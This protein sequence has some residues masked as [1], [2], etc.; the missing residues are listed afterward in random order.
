MAE[1]E[2]KIVKPIPLA[3]PS[4][5]FSVISLLWLLFYSVFFIA[6]LFQKNDI[7]F[8][9]F[10]SWENRPFSGSMIGLCLA[11][12]VSTW[13][14]SSIA[15]KPTKS[16]P[17][18]FAAGLLVFA[19][20]MAIV[21]CTY[22]GNKD[23]LDYF[24]YCLL[25]ALT[26]LLLSLNVFYYAFSWRLYLSSLGDNA[27]TLTR[28]ER[29]RLTSNPETNKKVSQVLFEGL[30]WLFFLGTAVA[31]LM[32]YPDVTS[33]NGSTLML[34]YALVAGL[35]PY[36]LIGFGAY[37]IGGWHFNLWVMKKGRSKRSRWMVVPML[38]ALAIG[39]IGMPI[40]YTEGRKHVEWTQTYTPEK[41]LAGDGEDRSRM[42]TDFQNKVDLQNKNG[43]EVACYLGDPDKTNEENGL[44]NW[45]YF[46]GTC[47][48]LHHSFD[49]YYRV[50]FSEGLVFETSTFSVRD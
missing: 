21:A 38:M 13:L 41:W 20:A 24:S 43:D 32:V 6:S 49:R 14:Y 5:T 40:A 12:F 7:L 23:G 27:I 15:K 1:N 44:L 37:L 36:P 22:L 29:N 45:D 10:F 50:S 47:S 19:L 33:L 25:I 8:H 2:E 28:W 18:F 35:T 42:L 26:L 4:A 9:N 39:V 31:C 17:L 3:K 16:V 34:L 48:G 11:L 46:L 30:S